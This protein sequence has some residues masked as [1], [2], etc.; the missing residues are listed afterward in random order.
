M[1]RKLITGTTLQLYS[2]KNTLEQGFQCYVS[3]AGGGGDQQGSLSKERSTNSCLINKNLQTTV[4]AQ[5]LARIKCFLHG[6]HGCT[7]VIMYCIALVCFFCFFS[8]FFFCNC[9][10]VVISWSEPYIDMKLRAIIC[11]R[12]YWLHEK[13]YKKNLLCVFKILLW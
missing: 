10:F 7:S 13:G 11:F 6:N 12:I 3:W 2:N 8:F 5:T 4:R 1:K 9:G